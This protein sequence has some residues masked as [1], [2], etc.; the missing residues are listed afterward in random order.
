[1]GDEQIE[2]SRRA[3]RL[4]QQETDVRL[5]A[6]TVGPSGQTLT[7]ACAALVELQQSQFT[8]VEQQL[9]APIGVDSAQGSAVRC[10]FEGTR[11]DD[12]VANTVTFTL[13]ER[14]ADSH[15]LML[16][17]TVPQPSAGAT[18]VLAQLNAMACGASVSFGVALPLC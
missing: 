10:G 7:S 3:V 6:V 15:V 17:T 11:T 18:P 16:R 13:V 12:G 2:D 9:V 8:D 4:H 5:Q 1:M 14:L